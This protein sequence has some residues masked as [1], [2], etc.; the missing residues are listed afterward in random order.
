MSHQFKILRT[1]NSIS[2]AQVLRERPV[3]EIQKQQ[4]EVKYKILSFNIVERER[5]REKIF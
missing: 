3:E 5:E 1:F 4:C 2:F